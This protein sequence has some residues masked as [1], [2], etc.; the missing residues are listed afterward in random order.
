MKINAFLT[1]LLVPALVHAQVLSERT[2]K[3]ELGDDIVHRIVII[4]DANGFPTELEQLLRKNGDGTF[5]IVPNAQNEKYNSYH[6]EMCAKMGG[7]DTIN[8]GIR[9][10]G[11]DALDGISCRMPP[12]AIPKVGIMVN[13]SFV[14]SIPRQR[15]PGE[16]LIQPDVTPSYSE[17][18]NPA[19]R[20]RV[21]AQA[22]NAAVRSGVNTLLLG[23]ATYETGIGSYFSRGIQVG[24]CINRASDYVAAGSRGNSQLAVACY[25]NGAGEIAGFAQS[26]L[27]GAQL[28]TTD[29]GSIYV[30]TQ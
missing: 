17:N 12:D 14:E 16:S 28:C 15:T 22:P 18:T 11:G 25:F 20:S 23:A 7:I 9:I 1:A 13:G 6:K 5:T 4:E 10:I 26:C 27:N 24:N 8:E 2:V 30:T 29:R 3:S 19:L 21:M